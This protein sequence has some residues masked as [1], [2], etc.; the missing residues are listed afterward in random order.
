MRNSPAAPKDPAKVDGGQ[1]PRCLPKSPP[2]SPRGPPETAAI[3][4]VF[5]LL[6]YRSAELQNHPPS[7]AQC[8]GREPSPSSAPALPSA[9]PCSAASATCAPRRTHATTAT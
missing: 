7:E 4:G 3:C 9:S 8:Q 6:Q 1:V 2:D 5:L